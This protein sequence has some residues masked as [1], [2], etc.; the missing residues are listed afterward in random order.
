M[1]DP[2]SQAVSNTSISGGIISDDDIVHMLAPLTAF[3]S[4]LI[5]VSGGADS[6]ALMV[7]VQRWLETVP[8]P[9]TVEV[10]TIDHGLRAGAAEEAQWVAD[11]AGALG[12]AHTTKCWRGD[13]PTSGLQAAA[14]S[15]RYRLL[16]E[17]IRERR[18]EAP[19]AI[20]TAHTQEDQAETVVMRLARGSGIDGLGAMA[21]KRAL[22][23]DGLPVMLSRPLL[24]VSKCRLIGFLKSKQQTWLE[25]PSNTSLDFE[26]I[27]L[28]QAM[29]QLEALGVSA[30]ALARSATRARRAR[31][32]LDH[33]TS[34]F[35]AAHVTLSSGARAELDIATFRLQPDEVQIRI[36]TRLLSAFGGASPNARLSQIE[37]LQACLADASGS[38]SVT[39]G[40]C[41]ISMQMGR[42]WIHRESGRVALPVV[43]LVPGEQ[44]VWDQRFRISAAPDEANSAH[45]LQIRAL[46]AASFA[47]IRGHLTP[48]YAEL[49]TAAA[50]TLPSFWCEDHLI[51]VP[52]LNVGE[53]QMSQINRD[54]VQKDVT[55]GEPP[56]AGAKG[57][58]KVRQNGH[59]ACKDLAQAVF[60]GLAEHGFGT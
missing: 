5:A 27:R 9:P 25:D 58:V 50:Q 19:A 60:I 45:T 36:L 39:L 57:S 43:D 59:G 2:T 40:G 34:E 24:G 7:M 30:E 23:G 16:L 4:L 46:D 21:E 31:S 22:K 41:F 54:N 11:Q 13:K 44:L 42:L 51:A 29:P 37:T 1:V 38:Q 56:H 3:K 14:R 33:M 15:A 48:E 17:I 20:V 8:H 10:G 6:V 28:R 35:L 18:M 55:S 26:R 47:V 32:A 12:L 49:S 53:K 52:T